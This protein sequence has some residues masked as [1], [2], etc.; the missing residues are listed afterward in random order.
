MSEPDLMF[1]VGPVSVHIRAQALATFH[2][3]RQRRFF[4]REAGGQ[5]FARVRGN[6]WEIVT[7]TGPRARDRRDRFSFWPHRASEQDEIYEHHALGLE[8]VGDWHTHPQN[9][10]S[11]SSDDLTSIRNVVRRSIH[12]PP[13]FLLLIVGRSPFPIGLWA[14]FHSID[15]T[16]SEAKDW[17]FVPASC[18]R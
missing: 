17:Q 16:S 13:G 11:P 1:P 15:G 10:P 14:S 7:A 18:V 12:H 6:D 5:L 3:Y 9:V 8:Y 4:H 2:A